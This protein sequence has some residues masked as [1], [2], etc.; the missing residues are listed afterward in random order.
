MHRFALAARQVV[1][2]VL[3]NCLAWDGFVEN[4]GG[5]SSN[6]AH[7][8]L[9]TSMSTSA[10]PNYPS[11]FRTLMNFPAFHGVCSQ[12]SMTSLLQ[13]IVLNIVLGYNASRRVVEFARTDS[14]FAR[15][16][17]S[18]EDKTWS[19]YKLDFQHFVGL[20]HWSMKLQGVSFVQRAPQDIF[21]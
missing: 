11:P 12:C 13:G 19:P 21:Y 2:Y 4:N 8:S 10:K 7:S 3:W 14:W 5:I 9:G 1:F 16:M 18:T 17:L 15:L 6:F 20:L